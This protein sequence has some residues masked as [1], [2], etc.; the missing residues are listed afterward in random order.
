MPPKQ[1]AEGLQWVEIADFTPGIISNSQYAYATGGGSGPV[2]GSKLGQAQLGTVGCIALPNGGI[3]P[4]PGLATT[5][6]WGA[7]T[8]FPPQHTPASGFGTA[9][10]ITG[11]FLGPIKRYTAASPYGVTKFDEILL[12]QA[13]QNGAGAFSMYF[14]SIQPYTSSP[15]VNPIY[16]NTGGTLR[17]PLTTMTAGLTRANSSPSNPGNATWAFAYYWPGGTAGEPWPAS[18]WIVGCY[19][20]PTGGGATGFVP[21]YILHNTQAPGDI[22]VHQNRIVYLQEASTFWNSGFTYQGGNEEFCYTDPPNS[23][24]WPV[25]AE[26]FVQEDSTG[27]GAWGSQNASTLFLV[28]N[29]IGGV[30]ISGDLNAPTVTVLPGVM[31]TYGMVS[32]GASTSIGFIYASNNRGLWSWNG[33][34]TSQKISEQLEDNFMVNT[35]LPAISRG[36]TVDIQRWGDWIVVTNDWLY[37]I[38]TGGWWKMPPG[39]TANAHQWYQASTDG[40]TLYAALGVPTSTCAFEA[41]S[42]LQGAQSYTWKSYPIRPPSESKNRSMLVREVVIRAQGAGTVTVTLTGVQGTTTSGAISP[43]ST[44]TFTTSPD[45]TQ[46]SMQ[47]LAVGLDAQ[48]VQITVTSTG[49][50]ATTPAPILYSI[51]VGYT[52][53]A[54]LVSPA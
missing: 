21:Y 17:Q 29:R 20:D 49:T 46:P 43:S 10:L 9:N 44:L 47:R 8:P 3:G 39:T 2:P 42:R 5:F 15:Y 19:P 27:Y 30:V 1:E 50:N 41:Y 33:G 32:R 6:P 14:D 52:D 51:A 16:T 18:D 26:V 53:D 45:A 28:K 37:D 48:D 23:L 11:F 25:Q 12:G 22:L 7:S 4:L 35:G 36:P 54:A 24:T 38:N 40:M 34:N 13:V 31:P